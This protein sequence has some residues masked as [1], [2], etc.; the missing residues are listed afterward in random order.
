GIG[1]A[2]RLIA[3]FGVRAVVTPRFAVSCS[4]ELLTAAGRLA[5]ERGAPIMTHLAESA[6]E[7]AEVRQRFP[8]VGSYTM[9]YAAAHLLTRRTVLA[10]AIHLSEHD[11]RLVAR[12]GA[13]VAHCPTANIALRSGRMPLESLLLH[14]LRFGLGSDVGAGPSLSMWHVMAAYM[15]VHA[16]WVRVSPAEALYRATIGGGDILGLDATLTP[17]APAD[18]AAFR[19]PSGN[20]RTGADIVRALAESTAGDPE[21]EALITVR[22]GEILHRSRRAPA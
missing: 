9:V 7:V 22:G 2:E 19:R 1:A 6:G 12:A 10:H 20:L 13:A 3:D 8:G 5:D 4:L 11:L 18:L 14:R 21:P 17:G 16:D 15:T